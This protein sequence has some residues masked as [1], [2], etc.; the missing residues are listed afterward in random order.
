[1][2]RPFPSPAPDRFCTA[3]ESKL[4]RRHNEPNSAWEK[5]I[6][7]DRKCASRNARKRQAESG[8]GLGQGRK[9]NDEC[10][11]MTHQEIGEVL[12]VSRTLVQLIERSALRKLRLAL[13]VAKARAA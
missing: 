7:C 12:G 8:I 9:M 11:A 5:R 4:V 2:V 6:T 10:Y 1:M 3:C 13:G